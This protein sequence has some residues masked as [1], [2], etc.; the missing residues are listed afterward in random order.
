M[1]VPRGPRWPIHGPPPY[2][3]WVE[4]RKGTFGSFERVLLVLTILESSKGKWACFRGKYCCL[5]A[6]MEDPRVPDG[7][8]M[9]LC[10][11]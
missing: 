1:G 9:A 8:Y 2:V 5:G 6:P 4:R 7:Q 11:G 3:R 10:H